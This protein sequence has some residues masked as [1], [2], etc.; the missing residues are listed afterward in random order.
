[1]NLT[2]ARKRIIVAVDVPDLKE[3][4]KLV[5]FLSPHVG[6]FKF[7]LELIVRYGVQAVLEA[8]ENAPCRREQVFIDAK[9]NDIPNTVGAAAQQIASYEVGMF[10]V[11]SSAGR[12]AVEAAVAH[13]N[14]SQVLAVTVLTSIDED[15]CRG[16][17]GSAPESIVLSFVE[18]DYIAGVQGVICSPQEL[19][20]LGKLSRYKSLLKVTPGVR[21]TW[22]ATNDQKR[23]MTPAE[24]IR[25]GATH[26]VIGRPITKAP[27]SIG[28][29]EKAAD[30]IAEEIAG[31]LEE[32]AV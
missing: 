15:E 27:E 16:I 21:P 10:N 29:M 8:I 22:A 17:F 26:L 1:M 11:H 12:K 30:L 31:A 23:V 4:H 3:A 6:L 18:M 28:S 7:G 19:S 2:E 9:L 25:A 5:S 32:V 13:R 14:N 20:A 24:A